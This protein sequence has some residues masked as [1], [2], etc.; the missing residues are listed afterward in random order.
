MAVTDAQEKA[1]VRAKELMV[2]VRSGRQELKS[3]DEQ[4]AR[5]NV[6]KQQLSSAILG[7][8]FRFHEEVKVI[9]T[10][11]DQEPPSG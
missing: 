6:R 9:K 3:I 11:K 5:L 10:I 1:L 7:E 8:E 4:I 2:K